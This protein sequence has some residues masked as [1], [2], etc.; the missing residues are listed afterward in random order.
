[1]MMVVVMM[2]GT[3]DIHVVVDGVDDDDGSSSETNGKC[4][5]ISVVMVSTIVFA[6]VPLIIYFQVF[7]VLYSPNEYTT[8]PQMSC[9]FSSGIFL[10]FLIPLLQITL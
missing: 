4:E 8:V 3:S 5:W 10:Q 7:C 2:E 9:T 1:M 6:A